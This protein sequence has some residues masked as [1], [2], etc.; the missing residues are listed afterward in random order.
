[1]TLLPQRPLPG[2]SNF[3]G[4]ARKQILVPKGPSGTPSKGESSANHNRVSVTSIATILTIPPPE[5]P[6]QQVP[7]LILTV[8]QT[9]WEAILANHNRVSIIRLVT[10]PMIPIPLA[11]VVFQ[12]VLSMI[13][14]AAMSTS[15]EATLVNHNRLS[16]TRIPAISIPPP[17]PAVAS[18][19][20]PSL[21]LAVMLASKEVTSAHQ[22]PFSVTSI[23][24]IP[25]ISIPPLAVAPQ[26]VLRLAVMLAA[27]LTSNSK[28]VGL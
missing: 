14:L 21:M 7:S 22:N 27:M 3:L 6:S 26:L 23:A 25:T 19:P 28:L 4:T 18:Q 1:M 11:A 8:V 24:T 12:P 2:I 10:V 13:L 9:T 20:V 5:D 15:E 17:P 16:V